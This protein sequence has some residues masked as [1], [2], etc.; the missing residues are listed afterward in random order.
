MIRWLV[1]NHAFLQV[2]LRRVVLPLTLTLV[3]AGLGTGLYY[4]RVTG[5]PLRMT[6]QVD[7]ATY[8]S[9]PY[10]LWGTVRPEPIYHHP[11]LR[12]FY[13]RER[14]SFVAIHTF[15]R[16]LNSSVNRLLEAWLFFLGP[17]LTLAFLPLPSILRDHRTRLPLIVVQVALAGALSG[18]W[19]LLHYLAPAT[20]ALFILIVQGLR[21]LSHWRLR[22]QLVGPS[23]VRTVFVLCCVVVGVRVFAAARHLPI[24]F[25]WP[26]GNLERARILRLLESTPGQH[27]VIVRYAADHNLDREWVYNRA[28]IDHAK[29]IWTRDMGSKNVELVSY[30][31]GGRFWTVNADDPHPLLED[32]RP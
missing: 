26:R 15:P 1:G 24:E 17:L 14:S 25:P 7:H 5:H 3:A 2:R 32:F 4:Q 9:T 19:F 10:F 11:I 23:I 31:H 20:G 6:Y 22:A 13:E 8:G 27:V 12:A 16:W 18:T 30:F 21:H 29:V 28:D